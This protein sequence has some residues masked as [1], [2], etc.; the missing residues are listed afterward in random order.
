M[1]WSA[2][3]AAQ[4]ADVAAAL[5]NDLTAGYGGLSFMVRQLLRNGELHE[6]VGTL[7]RAE[8]L[9][10]RAYRHLALAPDRPELPVP[11]TI[12]A[13]QPWQAYLVARPHEGGPALLA[14]LQDVVA[15]ARVGGEVIEADGTV[16]ELAI[17]LRA[18]LDQLQQLRLELTTQA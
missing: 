10:D 7:G 17:H 18:A 5:I 1:Q 15:Q 6:V 16:E 14:R 13:G 11:V 4:P 8:L 3:L 9:L 12:P 2:Y